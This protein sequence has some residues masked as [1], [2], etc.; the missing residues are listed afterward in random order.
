LLGFSHARYFLAAPENR[1]KIGSS[2]DPESQ[3]T[4]T[5]RFVL[6]AA[7][8]LFSSLSGGAAE[9]TKGTLS[10]GEIA[11]G[12]ISLFDGESSFGW[13]IQG[14]ASVEKGVLHLGGAKATKAVFT[15]A[16]G[17]YDL[18]MS[19]RALAKDTNKEVTLFW[20][21]KPNG[22]F[23]V[24]PQGA[25]ADEQVSWG[26]FRLRVQPATHAWRAQLGGRKNGANAFVGSK[27]VG[28]ST[29]TLFVPEG[30]RLALRDVRLKPAGLKSVFNGKDLGG[31]KE[32]PNRKSRFSVTKEGWLSLQDGPGDL[33]TTDKWGDFAL[34]IQCFCNGDFL[35]SGVFFRCQP[36]KYQ[37]GYE[38][39]IHN[40]FSAKPEKEYTLEEYDPKTHK[41]LGKKRVKYRAADYGTGAIYR[42]QPARRQ[43]AKDKEWFTMTVLAHGRH[44]AVWVNGI[45]VTDWTDNRPV[46]DNARDGC[47]LDAGPIS[48]QG[49]DKTTDLRFRNIRIAEL[50]KD[51]KNTTK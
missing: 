3:E 48:L 39:Q 18:H 24:L 20:H 28:P 9:S 30:H 37:Q 46:S 10:T 25:T 14:E 5:M 42:R 19:Y 6:V 32:F 16:F 31:W 22:S 7:A 15:T 27:D 51:V 49:H 8:F 38:A 26:Q 41:L 45:Q 36:D 2:P 43:A 35:N 1:G 23:A 50:P 17:D 40:K 44:M 29:L 47:R 33:Q 13:Q 11:E 12:W 34:Q 21:Q 4:C